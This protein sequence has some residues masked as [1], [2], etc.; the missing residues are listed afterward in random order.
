MVRPLTRARGAPVLLSLVVTL[1]GVG[2]PRV[3]AQEPAPTLETAIA[4]L[5]MPADTDLPAAAAAQVDDTPPVLPAEVDAGAIVAR[6]FDAADRM[7]FA[8]WDVDALADALDY[9]P[10][11]AFAFVRDRI[12]FDPYTGI[13]RDADGT[14]DARAGNGWDRALLLG[15][16]LDRMEVPVRYA[17]AR[18]DDTAAAQVLARAFAAPAD[19][20]PAGEV[21]PLVPVRAETLA[22]RAGRDHARLRAAL[23]EQVA[24]MG[25][26]DG[27]GTLDVVRDHAWVQAFVGTDWQDL[28]P[29]LADAV[30]GAAFAEPAATYAEPPAEL[31][32][33]VTLRLDTTTLAPG[34]TA[35]DTRT[36]L[37]LRLDA[38]DVAPRSIY[39]YFQPELGGT[40]GAIVRA[41]T[42]DQGW[43]P[44][45]LIDGE[46]T[47]GDAFQAGGRG[48][49]LFGDETP[50]PELLSLVLT[51]GTEGPGMDPVIAT[52][53]LLD[54]LPVDADPAAVDPA[55]IAPLPEVQDV[56][57]F[58]GQLHQVLVSTGATDVYEAAVSLGSA[59]WFAQERL[60]DPELATEYRLDH[61]LWPMEIGN[62][63]AVLANER[64]VVPGLTGRSDLRAVIDRPRAWLFTIGPDPV[65]GA[66]YA[67]TVDLAIDE[68]A[69]ADA[70][71]ATSPA[72]GSEIAAA[73]IW[74]GAL[75]T[76][77]ETEL[78][79]GRAG[80]LVPDGRR[81]VTLSLRMDEPLSVVPAGSPPPAG[82]QRALIESLAH[83]ELAVIPGGERAPA[84]FWTIDPATGRTRSV[85]EPGVRNGFTWGGNHV[86]ASLGGPRYV[87]GPG[88]E[89]LGIIKDGKFYPNRS[90]PPPETCRGGDSTGYVTI[91]GCV[92]VPGSWAL[93]I[94]L[95][96]FVVAVLSFA[97]VIFEIAALAY[98]P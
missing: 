6:G 88:G 20:L 14:L 1:A 71:A 73:R 65:T 67:S 84:D 58:T 57:V 29:T 23:G 49:D 92:S 53:T 62:R 80:A 21:L 13:L 72:S 70:G 34:A 44:V 10:A 4:A 19:P 79:I 36:V 69:I 17:T 86:N 68:I 54:R 11:Q 28:D 55:T 64:L 60:S 48:T 8:D 78:T 59:A 12:G 96:A 25:P 74:Y 50:V 31:R 83:G 41:L 98:D 27:A 95:G 51:I 63:M 35:A 18:L 82:A 42:G 24:T 22:A 66:G 91:L 94:F 9:D 2:A 5:A 75:Q 40:G 46:T 81:I 15:T 61:Q 45:V 39:L 7:A 89:D 93:G 33:S 38:A 32:H 97:I 85:T 76:A 90:G 52:R 56:P 26:P 3:A 87:V 37:D 16:L 47:L 77:L 43:T 30:A